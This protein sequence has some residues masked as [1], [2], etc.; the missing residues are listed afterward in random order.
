MS[1]LLSGDARADM[2]LEWLEDTGK[3]K[4]VELIHFEVIKL[5]HHG[6]DRYITPGFLSAS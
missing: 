4:L 2:I 3:L 6:S 5:P 1:V